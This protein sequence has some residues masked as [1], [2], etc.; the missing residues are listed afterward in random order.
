MDFIWKKL[1]NSVIDAGIKVKR[2]RSVL[3]ISLKRGE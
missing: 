2:F 1:D 3:W